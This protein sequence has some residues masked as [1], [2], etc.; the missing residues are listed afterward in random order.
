MTV[1]IK[2]VG[3]VG[4]RTEKWQEMVKFY[5][6]VFGLKIAHERPNGFNFRLPNGDTIEGVQPQEDNPFVTGPSRLMRWTTS[7]RRGPRWR[8]KV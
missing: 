6:D 2:G 4:L 7:R 8:P 3:W 1:Q 5:E